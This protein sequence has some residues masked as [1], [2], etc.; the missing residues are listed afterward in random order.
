MFRLPLGTRLVQELPVIWHKFP[1]FG[2][3][4]NKVPRENDGNANLDSETESDHRIAIQSCNSRE[5]IV[6]RPAFGTHSCW[7]RGRYMEERMVS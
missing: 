5:N 1:V 6:L 2:V 7:K 4:N 3:A